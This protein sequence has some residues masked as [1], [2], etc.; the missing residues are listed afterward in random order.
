MNMTY[1]KLGRIAKIAIATGALLLATAIAGCRSPVINYSPIERKTEPPTTKDRIA[2]DI[3][4]IV[5]HAKENK[6]KQWRKDY[7]SPAIQEYSINYQNLH[8]CVTLRNDKFYF[9]DY[10]GL[11]PYTSNLAT[12][13]DRVEDG[14]GFSEPEV[15]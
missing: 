2:K 8:L 14:P 13:T 6:S 10:N 9:I 12:F 15:N 7:V 11:R 3:E 1:G 4:F 5:N